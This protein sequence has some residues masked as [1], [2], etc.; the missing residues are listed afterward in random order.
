MTETETSSQLLAQYATNGLHKEARAL[1]PVASPFTLENG[2]KWTALHLAAHHGRLHVLSV[3]LQ[4]MNRPDG[5]DKNID[6]RDHRGRTALHLAARAGHVRASRMLL[7]A[8]AKLVV[9]NDAKET[10]VVAAA[11]RGRAEVVQLL[12]QRSTH[13]EGPQAL[14]AAIARAECLRTAGVVLRLRPRAARSRAHI[15]NALLDFCGRSAAVAPLPMVRLLCKL[16]ADFDAHNEQQQ[17]P[18]HFAARWSWVAVVDF[19]LA[20][21]KTRAVNKADREMKTPLI[22]AC[23]SA[24]GEARG[25]IIRLLLR[26]GADPN[27][28]YGDGKEAPLYRIGHRNDVRAVR[29]LVDAGARVDDEKVPDLSGVISA[30]LHGTKTLL[31]W[32]SKDGFDFSALTLSRI[33]SPFHSAAYAGNLGV[34]KTLVRLGADPGFIDGRGRSALHFFAYGLHCADRRLNTDGASYED[35]VRYLVEDCEIDP[36]LVGGESGSTALHVAAQDGNAEV[37][38]LLLRL[39]AY[40]DPVR[41]FGT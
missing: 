22:H 18:L 15:T 33:D 19:L 28:H 31:H 24:R 34:M 9:H 27:A 17:T 25:Q 7:D 29:V 10:P 37:V 5:S 38:K 6:V 3:F 40:V 12:L 20:D 16:G 1:L 14:A 21:C 39:G 26:H 32:Y 11:A 13:G 35:I 36:N 41:R 4:F 2:M 30:A 8:G 23:V